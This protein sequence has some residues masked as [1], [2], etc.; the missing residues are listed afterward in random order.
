MKRYMKYFTL[1]LL[2]ISALVLSGC[3]EDAPVKQET[4]EKTYTNSYEYDGSTFDVK[5]VVRYETETTVELWLSPAENLKT[6]GDVMEKGDYGVISVN[7]TYLGGRDLFKK[8]GSYAGF[9]EMRFSK[10]Q[11]AKAY[12]EMSFE[13]DNVTFYFKIE[14]LYSEGEAV[15]KEFSGS[16]KGGFTDHE[17]ILVNQWSFNRIARSITGG[18]VFINTDNEYNTTATYCFYD[19]EAYLHEAFSLTVPEEKIGT[20]INEMEDVLEITYDD[21]KAFELAHSA[22]II[23]LNAGLTDDVATLDMDLVNGSNFLAAN[24]SG[25]IEL[26]ESKPNHIACAV[27]EKNAEGEFEHLITRRT[28]ISKLFVNKRSSTTI[29][30]FGMSEDSEN[31]ERDHYPTLSIETKLAD[32]KYHFGTEAVGRFKYSDD[33]NTIS[34]QPFY[35][36]TMYIE[37]TSSDSYKIIFRVKDLT[38]TGSKKA[39]I[40]VFYEGTLN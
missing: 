10:G 40:E 32:G 5:S 4:I 17:Q 29:L 15:G 11:N 37:Q 35:E 39:D 26:D 24:F 2:S 18:K 34:E 8:S 33:H 1:A 9:N 36:S 3:E 31:S 27:Y 30:Y 12:I 6:I 38:I 22:N 16:Y 21:G 7:R 13:E 25:K 20:G 23:R 28:A 19:D 14:T